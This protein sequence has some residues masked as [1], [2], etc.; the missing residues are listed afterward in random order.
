MEVEEEEEVGVT[1][2]AKRGIFHDPVL[3]VAQQEGEVGLV[4]AEV[5]EIVKKS[6]VVYR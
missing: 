6:E 2:V 5:E 1:N 3:K 4:E